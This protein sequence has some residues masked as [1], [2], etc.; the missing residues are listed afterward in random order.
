VVVTLVDPDRTD[1][2][3]RRGDLI[4]QVNQEAVWEPAQLVAKYKDAK[5]AG[6]KELLLLIERVN[7]FHFM[8]LP[9]K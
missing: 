8:P 1:I 3:L 4:T 7:G 5:K 9:V 6:R 2:G